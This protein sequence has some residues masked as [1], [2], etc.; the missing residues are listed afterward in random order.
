MS[1]Q[2]PVLA[3]IGGLVFWAGAALTL[4]FAAAAIWLLFQGTQPAWWL[5]A[6][7]VVIGLLGWGLIR[8]SRVPFGDAINTG[9]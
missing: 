2:R 4:L 9:F 6:V 5:L 8:V 3:L 1:K 7:T